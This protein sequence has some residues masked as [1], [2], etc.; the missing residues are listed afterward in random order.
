MRQ[1]YNIESNKV[2]LKF[3]RYYKLARAYF[4]YEDQ[5]QYHVLHT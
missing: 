5:Y 1:N 4:F 3:G 2:L